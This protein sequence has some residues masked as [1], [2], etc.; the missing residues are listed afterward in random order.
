MTG[1]ENISE[2]DRQLAADTYKLFRFLKTNGYSR[3]DALHLIWG[4]KGSD[5]DTP[6]MRRVWEKI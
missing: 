2:E 1:I 3:E 5:V 6:G 4:D